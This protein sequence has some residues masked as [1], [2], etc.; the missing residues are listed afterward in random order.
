MRVGVVR[1]I[2]RCRLHQ[3]R[4][5]RAAELEFPVMRENAVP[6]FQRQHRR[7]VRNRF[8]L[9]I[10]HLDTDHNVADKLTLLRIIIP[11]KRG[12][13]ARLADVV[14]HRRRDQQILLQRRVQTAVRITQLCHI[15]T[16]L[17]QSADESMVHRL[18]CR[19][20][21]ECRGKIGVLEKERLQ[22][23]FHVRLLDF[24]D[25]PDEICP[26]LVDGTV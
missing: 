15:E 17:Q 24:I 2:Q 14:K 4:Y 10:N 20:A 18:G 7:K 22:Q 25:I 6:Q 13:F 23:R 12:Q 19:G 3:C 8:Q 21:P 1:V 16:V 26:H 5:L 11:R 9:L